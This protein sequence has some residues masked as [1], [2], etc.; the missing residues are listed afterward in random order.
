MEERLQRQAPPV[1]PPSDFDMRRRRGGLGARAKP[2]DRAVVHA[3]VRAC[4]HVLLLPG[5]YRPLYV[6][7][8]TTV[9]CFW[10]LFL[11]PLVLFP[12]VLVL[13]AAT[14]S[15]PRPLAE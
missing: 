10:F 11:S 9:L 3:C 14:K 12:Y 4:V 6:L 1:D 2:S 15:L 13:T 8:P 7:I 5:T